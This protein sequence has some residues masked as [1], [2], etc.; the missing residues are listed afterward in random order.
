MK[1]RMNKAEILGWSIAVIIAILEV[2]TGVMEG[3]TRVLGIFFLS[4]GVAISES[5]N[6]FL[7][8]ITDKI[9]TPNEKEERKQQ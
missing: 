4:L 9:V 8:T 6:D 1:A 7:N 5:L 2:F 3:D